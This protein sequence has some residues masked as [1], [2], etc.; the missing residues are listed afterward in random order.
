MFV[1][2]G[3]RGRRTPSCSFDAAL[4]SRRRRIRRRL[5]DNEA[6]CADA[7]VSHTHHT[8]RRLTHART[9]ASRDRPLRWNRAHHRG[10]GLVQGHRDG[11]VDR[12]GGPRRL[13]G[14]TP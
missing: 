11:G 14:R 8:H 5:A 13:A 7:G 6:F 3:R 2:R 4:A 10:S 9:P 1:R 12:C